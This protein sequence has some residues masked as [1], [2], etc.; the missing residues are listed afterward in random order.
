MA[1]GESKESWWARLEIQCAEL[2]WKSGHEEQTHDIVKKL[3]IVHFQERNAFKS[4]L[5]C[6]RLFG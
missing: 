3:I 4:Y 6:L 2:F 5:R 1:R